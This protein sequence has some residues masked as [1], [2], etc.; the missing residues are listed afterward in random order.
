MFAPTL[1]VDAEVAWRM[2]NVSESAKPFRLQCD[3][4]ICQP[5]GTEALRVEGAQTKPPAGG[6][7]AGGTLATGAVGGGAV[8]S[9]SDPRGVGSG[10]NEATAEAGTSVGTMTGGA[11]SAAEAV[12]PGFNPI[13]VG[14]G[15]ARA[16]GGAGLRPPNTMNAPAAKTTKRSAPPSP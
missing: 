9:G 4:K 13:N 2:S 14:G 7:V 6:S 8:T 16:I 11:V 15:V 5:P 3:W 10:R 12:E 1:A